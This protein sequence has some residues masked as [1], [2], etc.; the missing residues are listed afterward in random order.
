M[1]E[2]SEAPASAAVHPT[3]PHDELL[4]TRNMLQLVLDAIPA[5]V[6]W[7]DR[8]LGY[9]GCN[10][11]FAQDAGLSSPAE[12]VGK[13]DFDMIWRE[14]AP[15]YRADDRRV[16]DSGERRV[17][18]E[19]RQTSAKGEV[20]LQTSKI[21]LRDVAGNILGVLGTY[22][23]ITGRKQLEQSLARHRDEL[24]V[25]VEE[26]TQELREAQGRLVE[27]SRR[28]GMAEVSAGILHN[29]GN[30]LN[31]VNV[32]ASMMRET[33]DRSNLGKLR[34]LLTLLRDLAP[35]AGFLE[36]HPQGKLVVPFLAELVDVLERDQDLLRQT[37]RGL[38]Q[39]LEHVNAVIA[40]QQSCAS[41]RGILED[42]AL[43]QLVEDAL[44]IHASS[45][46][47]HDVAIEREFAPLPPAF[48][49]RHK[50]LQILVNL[51]SNAQ[52][53]CEGAAEP[54]VVVR[55]SSP[56]PDTLRVEVE[57]NG[58]G[59][60]PENLTRIFSFGFT[61]RSDG[62]GIGLH[63]AAIAAMELG[64]GLRAESDG[65]GHGARMVL[66]LPARQRAERS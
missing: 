14:Q 61:T 62:N 1:T 64:G 24:E 25:L 35:G 23:D 58:H 42:C 66:E 56:T 39:N 10:R 18:Y 17:N 38:A 65:P 2:P 19:E 3:L 60:D 43:D 44:R 13:N 54:R 26:R 36:S 33:L 40:L 5:R 46:E 50:L 11:L 15:L 63:T 20:W 4:E 52:Q 16:V 7:K 9:L 32:S 8:D 6:F 53:A 12:I 51:V 34:A 57:D 48:L 22:E 41:S 28:A 29:V 49:D 47:R 55:L 30:V 31:S 45:L 37:L 27:A 59:I 21:P